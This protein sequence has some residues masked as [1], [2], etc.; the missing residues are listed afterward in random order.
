MQVAETRVSEAGVRN[1]SPTVRR[2]SLPP[3][4]CPLPHSF[5]SSL[6]PLGE[7]VPR[8][9]KSTAPRSAFFSCHMCPDMSGGRSA[10]YFIHSYAHSFIHSLIYSFSD[11]ISRYSFIRFE[12]LNQVQKKSSFTVKLLIY[13][14]NKPHIRHTS[15]AASHRSA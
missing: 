13:P 12:L 4:G 15:S 8:R 9:Q 3:P 6:H 10:H 2:D 11:S 5:P 7:G 14:S 1:P